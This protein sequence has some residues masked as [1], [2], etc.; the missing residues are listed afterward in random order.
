MQE[1]A[2]YYNKTSVRYIQYIPATH[3]IIMH[4]DLFSEQRR[5]NG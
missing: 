1:G 3:I 4:I 5:E 2:Y